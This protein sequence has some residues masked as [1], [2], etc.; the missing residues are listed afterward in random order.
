MQGVDGINAVSSH[1]NAHSSMLTCLHYYR[2]QTLPNGETF[3]GFLIGARYNRLAIFSLPA[4]FMWPLF[5]YSAN[6]VDSYSLERCGVHVPRGDTKKLFIRH[7]GKKPP[8]AK[9]FGNLVEG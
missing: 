1:F 5:Y 7:V 8:S 9:I 2:S 4:L 3:H 6:T